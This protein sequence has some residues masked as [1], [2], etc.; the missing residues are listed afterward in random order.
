VRAVVVS[1]QP[2]TAVYNLFLHRSVLPGLPAPG[3]RLV[4]RCLYGETRRTNRRGYGKAKSLPY[5]D[6]HATPVAPKVADRRKER[7]RPNPEQPA[8]TIPNFF[9]ASDPLSPIER[10][11]QPCVAFNNLENTRARAIILQEETGFFATFFRAQ[12]YERQ[13]R[14]VLTDKIAAAAGK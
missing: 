12:Q 11:N 7:P 10:C 2:A 9:V 3:S 4:L 6:G 8:V 1:H 14:A 5:D 13:V